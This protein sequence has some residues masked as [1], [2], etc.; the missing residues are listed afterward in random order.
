MKFIKTHE[1]FLDFFKKEKRKSTT[2]IFNEDIDTIKDCFLDLEDL[3][4]NLSYTSLNFNEKEKFRAIRVDIDKGN[5]QDRKQQILRSF[6]QAS[7]DRAGYGTTQIDNSFLFY[8]I[9]DSIKFATS[10]LKEM[11]GL[12]VIRIEIYYGSSTFTVD[13]IKAW[14]KSLKKI[15][16]DRGIFNVSIVFR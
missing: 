2:D 16:K 3:G 7:Y 10:Y 9:E 6:V 14:Y 11:F 1:G 15:D 5:Y 8:E 13:N 4:F 12:D